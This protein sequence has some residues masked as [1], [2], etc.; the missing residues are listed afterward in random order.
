MMARPIPIS[1]MVT[2]RRAVVG[3][4]S[5]LSERM[6]QPAAMMYVYC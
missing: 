2:P 6:K 1:P 3:R 4:D 5:H